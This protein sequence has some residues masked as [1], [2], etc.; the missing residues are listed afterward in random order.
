[1]KKKLSPRKGVSAN[2]QT[3]KIT[4]DEI[5]RSN[6]ETSKPIARGGKASKSSKAVKD[7]GVK[8][9]ISKAGGN[10]L[11]SNKVSKVSASKY[12][13][14]G[15]NKLSSNRSNSRTI[16]DRS[17][18][19]ITKKAIIVAAPIELN[20][21]AIS[22][23][24]KTI[25][26]A[27][28]TFFS[29]DYYEKLL[30]RTK[31]K[32]EEEVDEILIQLRNKNPNLRYFVESTDNTLH[33][34]T[35]NFVDKLSGNIETVKLSKGKRKGKAV[36][37]GEFKKGTKVTITDFFGDEREFKSIAAASEVLKE[38][39]GIINNVINRLQKEA[40]TVTTGKKVLRKSKSKPRK[41]KSIGIYITVPEKVVSNSEGQL[42][43]ISY[44]YSNITVQGIERTKFD[45]YVE[46]EKEKIR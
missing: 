17:T 18:K 33:F 32:K 34:Q 35:G 2:K 46:E 31:G 11:N 6:K 30:R 27:D 36:K 19:G 22:K 15:A 43:S 4:K 37:T 40:E 8:R 12:K 23:L 3:N 7:T 39:N 9:I 28:G 16:K 45:Y 1:M 41:S 26:K 25:R 5:K 10:K 44:D 13:L 24:R 38:Q 42:V 29:K 14:S 20:K 21:N